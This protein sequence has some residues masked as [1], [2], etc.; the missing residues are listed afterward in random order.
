MDT[1]LGVRIAHNKLGSAYIAGL[2]GPNGVANK[3]KRM[4]LERN[5]W[6]KWV[7]QAAQIVARRAAIL[8]PKR[9]GNLS[10][11]IGGFASKRVTSNNKPAQY[12]F[13]GVVV[14]QPSIRSVGRTVA[15]RTYKSFEGK[16]TTEKVSYGKAI[17]FGRYY[18]ANF[19]RGAIRTP[20]NPYLRRARDQTRYD[21]VKMWNREIRQ[22]IESQDIKTEGL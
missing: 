8:A 5:K 12:V 13:G 19:Q 3:L 4:G 17:S 18:P 2:Y 10:R 22:W 14:A 16:Q 20:G 21:V 9:T 11:N 15:K 6:Q 1:N 7:K